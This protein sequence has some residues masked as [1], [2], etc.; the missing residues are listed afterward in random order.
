MKQNICECPECQTKISMVN[1]D[2]IGIL[3]TAAV[4]NDWQEARED[5]EKRLKPDIE[6]LEKCTGKKLKYTRDM[7]ERLIT[8]PIREEDLERLLSGAQTFASNFLAEVL[9]WRKKHGREHLK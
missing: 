9:D 7:I 4:D 8:K 3:W 5:V 6:S 1:R 2:L